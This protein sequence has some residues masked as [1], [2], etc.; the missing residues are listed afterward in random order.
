MP[1]TKPRFAGE[2]VD[3]GG[4]DYTVPPLSLGQVRELAPLIEKLDS[5]TKGIPQAEQIDAMIKVM[6]AALSRNYPD[7]TE[8]DLLDVIDLANM[9]EMI[10]ATMRTSGL[11]PR[12]EV[13]T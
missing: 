4:T 9:T 13:K 8:K 3:L 7:F 11:K 10:K 6:H 5:E 1:E 12:G 2:I